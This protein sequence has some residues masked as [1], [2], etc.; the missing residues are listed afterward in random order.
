MKFERRRVEKTFGAI[1]AHNISDQKGRRILRKG[2]L[3][4]EQEIATLRA[5]GRESVY[6]AELEGGDVGEAEAARSTAELI[7]GSD[8]RVV[9]AATGRSNLLAEKSGVLHVDVHR[10]DAINALNGVTLATLRDR[11]VVP[12]R[13]MLAS[14][15]IIPYGLPAEIMAAVEAIAQQGPIIELLELSP[16]RVEMMFL[17]AAPILAKLERDFREPL[18]ARLQK[19]G[20]T[21]EGIHRLPTDTD[22]PVAE[23]AAVLGKLPKR[24]IDLL[25]MAGETAIMDRRDIIP[26]AIEVA[27][28]TVESN[29]APVDPGNLLMIAYLGDLPILGA[30]GCAR[31][32][33]ENVVDWVLP[34]LLSGERLKRGDITSLGHG[35]LLEDIKERPF[36]RSRAGE[37]QDA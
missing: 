37:S 13:Q 12:E 20:S 31:S 29:G 33:K 22:D 28:G 24:Q 32:P 18:E 25:I 9:G 19:L 1:L 34:R 10:L 36:P 14:I 27:G 26:S 2:T 4:S 15:K 7:H 17:G 11:S 16:K 30:P 21:V 6:V 23:L 8:I 3:I 5:L 35:G